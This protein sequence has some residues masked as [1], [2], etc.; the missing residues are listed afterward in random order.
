CYEVSGEG[1]EVG[2]DWYDI[3]PVDDSRFFFV[4]GDVSGRGIGAATIMARLHF[5]V[6]AYAVQDDSPEQIMGKLGHLLTIEKDGS[7][8]TVLCALVDVPAHTV[9]LVNAGHPPPLLL[10]DG[11][12]D[13]VRT[14]VFPP[15][16]VQGTTPYEGSSFTVPAGGT[17]VAFTDGLVEKRNETIDAGLARLRDRAVGQPGDL[18]QLLTTILTESTTGG[19]DDDTAILAVR[20]TN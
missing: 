10:D 17:I 6:R 1:T 8:A 2:G 7:F 14:T 20:W 9:T 18:D 11:R 19:Y 4:L 16:G 3:I 13:Y 12:G 15:V 5:A